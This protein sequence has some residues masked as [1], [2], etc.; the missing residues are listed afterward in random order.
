MYKILFIFWCSTLAYVTIKREPAQ[1][2]TTE[3]CMKASAQI[4]NYMDESLNPCEDFYEYACG[5]FI[6]KT[7][8]P[9][10]R[11]SLTSFSLVQDQIDQQLRVILTE[12]PQLNETKAVKLAKILMKTCLDDATLNQKGNCQPLF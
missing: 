9:Q 8:I 12:E 4:R 5:K 3:S 6:R 10:D 7:P 1:I 2:C 11:S